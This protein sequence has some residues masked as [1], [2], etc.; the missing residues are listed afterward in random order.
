M[1]IESIEVHAFTLPTDGPDGVEQDGTLHWDSTT[2][3]L[4]R[5]HGEG[6]SGIGYTYADAS[7]AAFIESEL[8]P[9]A[10]GGDLMSP[11]KLNHAMFAAIRN[12]GRPGVG[13]MAVS[14]VDIALWDL[15]AHVLGLPLT[16]LLPACHDAVPVYGSGGFTNYPHTRL[17]AQLGGW[18]AQGIP[19]VKLKTSRDPAADP[20]RLQV[21]R[22][23]IGHA[24][25]LFTDAN[26]ALTPKQA[27][28]WAQRFSEEWGVRWFEEPVTSADL[29]GLRDV[30]EHG[31][32]GLDVAAGEYA[33]VPRDF[34]NL[35]QPR[36]VD[37]LQADVTRCGGIT[38]VLTAS[39][40]ATG[41]QIDLSAHCAPA[42]S[43]HAF[44]AVERLRHL[45][46]FHDHVR[47]ESLAFDG[48]LSPEDGVLRPD[49]ARAGLGLTV[50]WADLEPY[51]VHSPGKAV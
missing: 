33:F 10:R 26:G 18:V 31:P 28:Y 11:A 45:E 12:A 23:A 44:C 8:A 7:T 4:V 20:A 48:T 38:G 16:A 9:M 17:A 37:C 27:R 19:R 13:A 32:P 24:T 22:E 25:E 2:M 35:L 51:R 47:F 49:P 39:G 41:H 3:V 40:L 30:R 50:K 29:T 42:V 36:A 21:A 14:A 5:A 34:L 46:Y 1:R 43:A 15:K 6:R